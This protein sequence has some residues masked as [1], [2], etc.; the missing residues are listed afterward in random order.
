MD[1]SATV[2]RQAKLREQSK[3]SCVVESSLQI[4]DDSQDC[5]QC[6]LQGAH[7][8]IVWFAIIQFSKIRR[9]FPIADWPTKLFVECSLPSQFCSALPTNNYCRSCPAIG[10]LGQSRS[11]IGWFS[12]HRPPPQGHCHLRP[13]PEKIATKEVFIFSLIKYSYE[14]KD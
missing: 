11:P 10:Q 1:L 6:T 13:E 3:V 8:T 9:T 7:V 12:Q 4:V 5:W 2:L 14:E